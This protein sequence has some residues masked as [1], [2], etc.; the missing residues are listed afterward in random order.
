MTCPKSAIK[1]MGVALGRIGVSLGVMVAVGASVFVGL[2]I[3]VNVAL[4]GDVGITLGAGPQAK[5]ATRKQMTRI[6]KAL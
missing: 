2:G 6:Y 1:G 5:E 4:G 3:D